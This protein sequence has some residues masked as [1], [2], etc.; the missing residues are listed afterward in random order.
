VSYGLT[1]EKVCGVKIHFDFDSPIS[2][3][4]A[5]AVLDALAELGPEGMTLDEVSI[6]AGA[7]GPALDPS[8]DLEPLVIAALEHVRLF[9]DPQP[10][11]DL[12]R[13]MRTFLEPWREAPNRDERVLAALISPALWRPRLKVALYEALDQ[14]LTHHIAAIVARAF[15]DGQV[16]SRTVQTVVWVLRGLTIDRLRSGARSPVDLDLLTDF[17][18]AAVGTEQPATP[19]GCRLA[20]V[21]QPVPGSRTA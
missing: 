14:P 6:R 8:T 3:L 9:P 1:C 11:G 13:D 5:D 10:T 4:V 18:L 2:R 19:P 7:A 21:S 15:Q 16:P 12:R 17:L 20:H